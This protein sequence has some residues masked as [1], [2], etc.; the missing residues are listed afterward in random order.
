ML[1]RARPTLL[2]QRVLQASATQHALHFTRF[3][4]SQLQ[5]HNT[6]LGQQLVAVQL[7]LL[8]AQTQLSRAT[9]ALSYATNRAAG[10]HVRNAQLQREAAALRQRTETAEDA[11]IVAEQHKTGARENDGHAAPQ[12]QGCEARAE[13]P[14]AEMNAKQAHAL[15]LQA[16]RGETDV[17]EEPSAQH[18]ADMQDE[19]WDSLPAAVQSGKAETVAARPVDALHVQTLVEVAVEP[20]SQDVSSSGQEVRHMHGCPVQ[21]L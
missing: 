1:L 17:S 12:L 15:A 10:L 11:L 13:Q 16:Y 6:A 9:T 21:A 3:Q 14:S 5:H 2:R 20:Q 8:A 19:G 18:E 7:Q 4:C